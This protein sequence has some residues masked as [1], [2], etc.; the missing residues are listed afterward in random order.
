MRRLKPASVLYKPVNEEEEDIN[1][2]NYVGL[3]YEFGDLNVE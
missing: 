3:P 1:K 2:E